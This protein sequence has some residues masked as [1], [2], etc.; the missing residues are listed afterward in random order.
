LVALFSFFE[1]VAQLGDVGEGNYSV[2]DAF[3]FV[4]LTLPRR[5]LDLMPVSTLLGSIVALGLMADHGELLAMQA[6][7]MS[8]QRICGSV[9]ATGILLILAAGLLG[10]IVVPP[11][12]QRARSLRSRALSRDPAYGGI[13]L[14]Q[15]GFWARR[16]LAFIH[17]NKMFY[18]GLAAGLDIFECDAQGRLRMYRYAR[19]A[20]IQADKQWVLKDISQKTFTAQG[21]TTR[22]ST[23]LILDAFLSSAQVNIL[24]IP[25]DSLSSSDLQQYIGVLRAGGQDTDRYVLALWRKGSVPLTT[26]AM[27]LLSL[28][29]IFGSMRRIPAGKRIVTGAFIGMAFYF[30]DQMI[31]Q[32]GIFFNLDPLITALTP[33]LLIGSVALWKLRRAV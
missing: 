21:I 5:I 31:M 8:V 1:L 17:V 9:L 29:F 6:G 10:E 22:N 18:G 30:V 16:G 20:K 23:A 4:G 28:P 26:G 24:E 3:I 11:L 7:G 19:E 2:T 27:V 14:T 13:M 32:L 33:A 25:P 15:Q 12:E